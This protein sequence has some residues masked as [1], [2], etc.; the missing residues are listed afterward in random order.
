[1]CMKVKSE[2]SSVLFRPC[3]LHI[4]IPSLFLSLH[5]PS[6]RPDDGIYLY[7]YWLIKFFSER[8]RVLTRD[9]SFFFVIWL[10]KRNS[11]TVALTYFKFCMKIETL[12]YNFFVNLMLPMFF[13]TLNNYLSNHN[14]GYFACRDVLLVA[15]EREHYCPY[16]SCVLSDDLCPIHYIIHM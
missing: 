12:R 10:M 1:M 5:F 4:C 15:I 2:F 7:K 6:S 8:W 14:T 11:I 9:E 3:H 13:T 16:C